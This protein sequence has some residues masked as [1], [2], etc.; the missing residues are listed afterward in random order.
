MSEDARYPIGK[1]IAPVVSAPEHRQGWIRE[2]A[3]CPMRLREA[4]AGFTRVQLDT[5]YR[6]GGWTIRQVVHHIPDSH[7]NAYIRMKLAL[8]EE[9]PLIK[10]YDEAKWAQLPDAVTAPPEVSLL[11]LE[12]LHGRWVILLEAMT[13]ADYGKVC[14]HPEYPDGPLRMDVVLAMYAW[15]SRHHV[16]HIRALRARRRW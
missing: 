2:I 8:T 5:P 3:E 15:H 1:F 13:E 14:W 4:V 16:G 6:E 9:E 11:L 10:P 7:V 12:G